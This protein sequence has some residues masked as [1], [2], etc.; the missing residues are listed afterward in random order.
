MTPHAPY[1][2][3]CP[4]RQ[5]GTPFQV[6]EDQLRKI[7][8]TQLNALADTI[9]SVLF[10]SQLTELEKQGLWLEF[11]RDAAWSLLKIDFNPNEKNPELWKREQG[12]GIDARAEINGQIHLSEDKNLTP[13]YL[14]TPDMFTHI[15][16]PRYRLADPEHKHKWI[17]LISKL[18]A[19][20]YVRNLIKLLKIKLV[21]IGF[22]VTRSNFAMAVRILIR[23]FGELF[24]ISLKVAYTLFTG[25]T[26]R[27]RIVSSLS[28]NDS[29]FNNPTYSFCAQTS[30]SSKFTLKSAGKGRTL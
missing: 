15:I 30:F 7:D 5:F 22:K 26:I 19:S 24:K 8:I 9:D 12:K 3:N 16:L 4:E 14:V 13:T 10:C 28:W 27:D 20:K 23:K 21:E 29:N 6:L 18:V 17:L 11:A 2:K 25:P 1:I